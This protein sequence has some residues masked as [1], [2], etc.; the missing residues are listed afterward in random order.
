[1]NPIALDLGVVQIHWYSICVLLG[2]LIASYVFMNEGR[3]N[4]I[5]D[6]ISLDLL[7]WLIPISIIGA[8]IYFVIFNWE[9]YGSNPGD[10]L[11]IWEG[12]LAIHGG[13]IASLIF[14]IF[15]CKKYHLRYLK[16]LDIGMVALILGQAIGR[17]GNFFNQEAFGS[18]VT[19]NFLQSLYL[20][21]FII[22]GMHIGGVY[23]HPTFL[24][25]S[26]W[27]LTGFI[28]LILYRKRKF[29]KVGDLTGIYLIWYGIGRF[30]IE[31]LR[32][33]SLMLGSLKM[34]QIVSLIMVISGILI[35][36]Y[37]HYKKSKFDNLYHEEVK[38]L[39]E[40]EV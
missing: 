6:D 25:E 21:K 29:L 23:Y 19:L 24:Y 40:A 27:C 11:K 34:A 3:K 14:A 26:L 28:V 7:I 13:I 15:F 4:N 12:G 32:T 16:L 31:G 20:P 5:V 30:L 38:Y 9:Y 39:G 33:D 17:W 8:R 2:V 37:A 1:M 36:F 35:I 10:I 18:A 22:N